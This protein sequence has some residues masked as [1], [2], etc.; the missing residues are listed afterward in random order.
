MVM[1]NN[2]LISHEFEEMRSQINLLKEQLDKQ[3]IV[4][5]RHIRHSMKVKATD[6][7]RIIRRTVF[8]GIFAV[9]YCPMIFI[10]NDFSPAFVIVTAVMLAVCFAITVYQYRYMNKV[11]FSQGNL[12]EIANAVGKLRKH[13]AQWTKI[14]APL[15]ILPWMGWLL[16]ESYNINGQTG[17]AF[18]IGA[19]VG[20]IIGGIVGLNINRKV[21]SKA[22]EILFQLEEL[23]KGE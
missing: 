13:Y 4:N 6:L 8:A 9:L 1:E 10:W 19:V 17:I 21:I 5:D 18:S 15:I 23:Q 3:T 11:D 2:T 7:N 16:Y 20:G 14:A 22:D 12:V